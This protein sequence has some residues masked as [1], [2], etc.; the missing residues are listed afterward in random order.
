MEN[1]GG[2]EHADFEVSVK[3][4]VDILNRQLYMEVWSSGEKTALEI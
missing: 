2:F 1:N 4:Q 3:P